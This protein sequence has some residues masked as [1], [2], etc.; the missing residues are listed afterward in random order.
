[1]GPV[2]TARGQFRNVFLGKELDNSLYNVRISFKDKNRRP[3]FKFGMTLQELENNIV[4][5]FHS[6]V[7]IVLDGRV[8]E[9][10][11]IDSFTIRRVE[12]ASKKITIPLRIMDRLSYP[13]EPKLFH[14]RG[15][16][17]TEEFINKSSGKRAA[18]IPE[19]EREL[20]SSVNT[21]EV[22]VV[23][24]RHTGARD[25]LFDFLRAINLHPVEWSEATKATGKG[26]PYVGEILDAISQA[27]AVVVLFTP[28][29]E[30]RLK[31]P[32]LAN[33]DAA[34][35]KELAGQPRPNVFFE[36]GMAMAAKRD[37]TILVKLGSPRLFSDIEGRHI[38][39]L[40]GSADSR[41]ELAQRLETAGCPVKRFGQDWLRA[42]DFD[43][44]IRLACE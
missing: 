21:R 6:G 37:R 39:A 26:S 30:A 18:V 15:R 33:D 16:D 11:D 8:I 20:S 7:T 28:D 1:M 42:G 36:A 2:R 31:I 9:I 12:N 5:P 27:Q 38:V 25:A 29:D 40:N 32:L 34:S 19:G 24:G 3:S 14:L 35:E 23:H 43:K 10:R 13:D 17:V 22:F 4:A 44:A 41:S